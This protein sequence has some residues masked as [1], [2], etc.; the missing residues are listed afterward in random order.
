MVRWGVLTLPVVCLALLLV[1]SGCVYDP[2][3]RP[4]RQEQPVTVIVNNSANVTQSFEVWAV[5]LPAN[6]TVRR[7]DG[8]NY[9]TDIGEGLSNR[10]SGDYHVYTAVEPPGSAYLDGR[11]TLAPG[12]QN[13]SSIEPGVLDSDSEEKFPPY[14]AVI[15]IVYQDENEI[16]SWVSANCDEQAL[17]GL[18]VHS[19]PDPPGGVWAGYGCH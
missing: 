16:T 19:Y 15:V 7:D 4:S 2:L 17:V 6:V 10:N 14:F 1:L 3:N 5:T 11:Y 18:E 8:E 13:R 12:E 9:T